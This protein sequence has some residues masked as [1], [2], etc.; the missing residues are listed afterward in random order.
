MISD[1]QLTK[2]EHV[3]TTDFGY[4]LLIGIVRTIF[5]RCLLI[6]NIMT[7]EFAGFS[8]LE[9]AATPTRNARLLLLL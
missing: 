1:S 4:R 2:I 7:L 3:R 6:G 8:N 5:G 9:L